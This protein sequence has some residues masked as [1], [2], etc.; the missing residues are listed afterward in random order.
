MLLRLPQPEVLEI[1]GVDA[2]AFAQSQFCNDVNLL[3]VG[4]WQWSA[5]LNPQ[6]RVRW[7]FHLLRLDEQ[8]LMAI[9]RGGMASEFQAALQPYVF[10]AKLTLAHH[11]HW[12]ALGA[13]DNQAV[14]QIATALFN[15]MPL[16]SD[17][18]Q[19]ENA[20]GMR[21]PGLSSRL[22]VLSTSSIGDTV[23]IPHNAT[24]LE[25]WRAQDIL[26]G[27]VEIGPAATAQFLPQMLGFERIQAISFR[28]G[29]YPGQEVVARVHFKGGNKRKLY[30]AE[31]DTP[32]VANALLQTEAFPHEPAGTLLNSCVAEPG[33]CIALAVL[34]EELATTALQISSDPKAHLKINTIN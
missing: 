10:R 22:M 11:D 2:L 4:S 3:K 5:W 24:A 26:A 31:S 25:S 17:L 29:C 12:Q 33:R 32:I 21:L 14:T 16:E 13:L 1:T 27:L 20:V 18:A 28:K 9:L 7:F 8:R 23:D 30:R 15:K 34:R 19:A 6:G